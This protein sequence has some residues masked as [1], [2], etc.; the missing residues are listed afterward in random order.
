MANRQ[1]PKFF[2]NI[3]AQGSKKTFMCPKFYT[4]PVLKYT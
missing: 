4:N 1:V 2:L 3:C